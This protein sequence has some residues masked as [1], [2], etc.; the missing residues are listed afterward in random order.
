MQSRMGLYQARLGQPAV[1][2]AW[3]ERALAGAPKNADVQFRAAVA[4]E[5]AAQRM[6]AIEHLLAAKALGYP[7]HLIESEPDFIALRRDPHYQAAST[8]GI[9]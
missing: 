8:K 5:L 4:S 1:A 3:T 2:L 6:R 9:K 7:A